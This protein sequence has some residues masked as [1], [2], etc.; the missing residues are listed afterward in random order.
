MATNHL[1]FDVRN[2]PEV[3]WEMRRQLAQILRDEAE[4]E[5]PRVARKLRE[6]A[7]LF[8]VGRRS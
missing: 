5:D 8:E 2:M 1:T 4:G 7:A 3:L 6:I